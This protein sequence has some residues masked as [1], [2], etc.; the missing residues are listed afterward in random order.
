MKT[1][2]I[3]HQ[4]PSSGISLCLEPA[5]N[6]QARSRS[7]QD[8]PAGGSTT[9]EPCGLVP[10]TPPRTTTLVGRGACTAAGLAVRPCLCQ[11]AALGFKTLSTRAAAAPA[12]GLLVP[13]FLSFDG[14][15][16]SAAVGVLSSDL[17]HFLIPACNP[18]PPC[19]ASQG[20]RLARRERRRRPSATTAQ[21]WVGG[22]VVGGTQGWVPGLLAGWLAGWLAGCAL[23]C[24]T[25][26]DPGLRHLVMLPIDHIRQSINRINPNSCWSRPFVP[27]PPP[28]PS[29]RRHRL[30]VSLSPG[31]AE[32]WCNM[33]V[34]LKQQVRG[35]EAVRYRR[36]RYGSAPCSGNVKQQTSN[37][38]IHQWSFSGGGGWLAA[39]LSS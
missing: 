38:C 21:R 4:P 10:P 1:K 12:A 26:L 8:S 33:G 5:R 13:C 23:R 11:H 27:S 25:L 37:A 6:L 24:H 18:S 22:W 20:W 28:S 16:L 7:W 30:Q 14:H 39:G 31:Y 19:L 3:G 17:P 36:R 35:R 9:S 32:A 15:N 34:L 2:K 29:C